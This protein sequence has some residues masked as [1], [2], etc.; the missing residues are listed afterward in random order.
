MPAAPESSAAMIEKSGSGPAASAAW[1]GLAGK[2]C[3]V[4]GAAS[5]I[6]RA[7]ALGL[8]GAGAEVALLDRDEAGAL[9]VAAQIEAAGGRAL[10]VPCDTSDEAGV[11]AA[12][13]RVRSVLGPVW[14]LVNNAGLL[15]AGPLAEVSLADWNHVLGVNLTGYLLCAREFGRDMLAARS[16]AMVHIASVAALHPQTRSG[17]Y[18]PSKAGV[19]L[20]SKQLAAEWGP[21][22]VRSNAICPGMIRTALSAKFYEEPDFEARRAAVTA[23]RR[24]GE[25]QDIAEPAMFLLSERAAY[26]NGTELVVDGGLDCMLMDMVPRPGF[27]STPAGTTENTLSAQAV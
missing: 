14:G 4:S 23:S 21:Q 6:G 9:A 26:V 18:S 1:L 2:V 27:N 11:Q 7:V 17:S 20:L 12:A 19:L 5:G 24:V 16:G 8:A 13:A 10:A 15:R 25:P 22:G 3:V